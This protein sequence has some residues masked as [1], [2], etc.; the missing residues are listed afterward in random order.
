V[1]A[2]A[3]TRHGPAGAAA[4]G[5]AGFRIGLLEA[6]LAS[7]T[8]ELVRRLG[9]IPL[10]APALS[11]RPLPAGAAVAAFL[12]KLSAGQLDLLVVQTGV[13]VGAL[14]HEARQLGRAAEL[15]RAMA[16]VRIVSRGPKPAAALAAHGLRPTIP[17]PSPY[18]TAELV[19][20]FDTLRLAALGVGLVHYG[21][22]NRSVVAALRARGA[23]V[24]ELTLYEWRLPDDIVPLR[25][26]VDALLGGGLDAVVF[27]TQVQVRHLFAVTERRLHAAVCEAL[28]Q[29]VV[30]GAVGPTCAEALRLR[31]VRS[32]VVPDVPKLRPLLN[33]LFARL[34][35]R[36]GRA[37]ES[38]RSCRP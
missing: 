22:Q 12:D 15:R 16:H 29:R 14:F 11:E 8:A 30:T 37:G 27:T 2:G 36:H 6:R 28:E 32:V 23:A 18:T 19:A 33:A 9:G 1:P 34:A 3:R 17:V 13:G 24:E 10:S 4:S 35:E 25:G 7:E 38:G 21:E 31:G 5:P 20:V 26:L